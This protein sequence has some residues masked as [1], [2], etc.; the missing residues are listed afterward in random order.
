[1]K[2]TYNGLAVVEGIG[3]G[4]AKIVDCSCPE[5]TV[6]KI[7]DSDRELGRFVRALK[8]YC[9]N[10][11][12]QIKL[13]EK[14]VGHSESGILNSHIKMTHDLALQSELISKISNGMCAE[15]ATCE[16]CDAYIAR[17]LDADVDFVRQLAVDVKD[18][19]L[20]VLNLLLKKE[21]V[22]VEHFD[23]DVIIVAEEIT[24][25]VVARVDREHTKGIVVE[26]GNINSHGAKLAKAMGIPGVSEVK[27][28]D[29]LIK[30]GEYVTLNGN[31]GEVIVGN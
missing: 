8:A 16:I 19:K 25:S 20:G 4:S 11:R 23:E 28:V 27:G 3:K 31:T 24:P 17:F 7:E 14:T 10:T 15:Q 18:V 5:F 26:F 30:E 6:R 9:E 22:K 21:D 1:M 13:V 12:E 2:R 29:K